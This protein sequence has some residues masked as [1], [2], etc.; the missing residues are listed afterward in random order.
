MSERKPTTSGAARVPSRTLKAD[1]A[2]LFCSAVLIGANISIADNISRALRETPIGEFRPI[3]VAAPIAAS[4]CLGFALGWLA[5]GATRRY[6]LMWLNALCL[7][8][9]G[10]PISCACSSVLATPID[11]N[12][13]C[14]SAATHTGRAA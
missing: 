11:L 8:A 9:I 1:G 5:R 2:L 3:L 7:A 12:N 14:D 13:R 6:R 10:W 4:V